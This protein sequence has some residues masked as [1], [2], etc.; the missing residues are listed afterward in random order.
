MSRN[1]GIFASALCEIAERTWHS[2][3]AG[4]VWRMLPERRIPNSD[5]KFH[6]IGL[7]NYLKIEAHGKVTNDFV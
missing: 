7:A 6:P 3:R 2:G 1:D 4:E 5:L